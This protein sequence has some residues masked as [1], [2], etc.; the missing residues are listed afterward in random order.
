LSYILRVK[1]I[2]D[3]AIR[4]LL[5]FYKKKKEK[6]S[7]LG[8]D[9]NLYNSPNKFMKHLL[10]LWHWLFYKDKKH[11]DDTFVLYYLKNKDSLVEPLLYFYKNDEEG[12]ATFGIWLQLL[13]IS[14]QICKTL[15]FSVCLV[16]TKN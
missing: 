9:S 4:S 7:L 11:L 8:F 5:Y 1:Q 10:L 15:T 12:N 3:N 16:N 2:K 13:Q 6:M 14:K